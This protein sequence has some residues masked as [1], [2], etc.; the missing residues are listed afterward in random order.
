MFTLHALIQKFN[1]SIIF[2]IFVLFTT[3]S[4]FAQDC[5]S[6]D[7]CGGS[8]WC[9]SNG[10]GDSYCVQSDWD[11]CE[12]NNCYEGDGDCDCGGDCSVIEDGQ[13]V[14]SECVGNLELTN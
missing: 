12:N 5:D 9:Y 7:D 10:D 14:N 11:F 8:S 4:L 1:F 6:N 2:S 3:S 13:F